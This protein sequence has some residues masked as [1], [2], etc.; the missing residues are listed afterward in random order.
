MESHSSQYT[1]GFGLRRNTSI[2]RHNDA[3]L[4]AN[5]ARCRRLL[6][7]RF[8]QLVRTQGRASLFYECKDFIQQCLLKIVTCT[9][10]LGYSPWE[11]IGTIARSVYRDEA[12][13]SSRDCRS[14]DYDCVRMDADEWA[15]RLDTNRFSE[16][17]DD[18]SC[19]DSD[20]SQSEYVDTSY[21]NDRWAHGI[22]ARW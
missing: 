15:H 10:N 21:T 13:K 8:Y 14:I 1:V 7:K 4:V 11:Y 18:D 20:E 2:N 9:T 16:S 6:T 17:F 3:W 12:I 22:P 5:Y 19:D